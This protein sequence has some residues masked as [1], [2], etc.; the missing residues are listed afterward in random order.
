MFQKLSV[1]KFYKCFEIILN[2]FPVFFFLNEFQ[3]FIDFSKEKLKRNRF[4]S[5]V[6]KQFGQNFKIRLPPLLPN[7]FNFLNQ[8]LYSFPF[9]EIL[10]PYWKCHFSITPDV[11]VGWMVCRSV[12]WSG[13]PSFLKVQE[14][15]ESL[16][17]FFLRAL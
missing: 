1:L 12:G 3:P 10:F 2:K 7:F 6:G 9:T 14:V 16:F 11:R 15:S 13:C 17:H 4:H 8:T 5:H